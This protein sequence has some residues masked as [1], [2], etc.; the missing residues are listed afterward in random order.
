MKTRLLLSGGILVAWLGLAAA[1]SAQTISSAANQTFVVADPS[2]PISPITITDKTPPAIKANKNIIVRIPAG[3]NMTWDPT[4]TTASFTG[5]GASKVSTTVSYRNGNLDLVINVTINFA[6]GDQITVSGLNFTNFTAP[7][8]A[9]SLGLITNG[10]GGAV[11]ATDNRT[12]TIVAKVYAVAVS[13]LATTA[14]QLPSNGVNYTVAFTVTNTGNGSTSYDLLTAKQP[15]TVITT[16]SIA[17]AGITQGANPDSARLT[18]LLGGTS[19][20]ATVT[21][22]VAMA[23]SGTMDTLIFKARAVLSPATADT[24]KLTV[25]VIRP[26]MTIAKSVSPGGTQLP[27]ANLTYT[28]A[29]SNIGSSNAGRG[30]APRRRLLPSRERREHLARR[31]IGAGRLLEQRRR[32]VD[33]RANERRVRRA[34]RI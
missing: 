3:L 26:T 28:V 4:I 15:G 18:N 33:V 31:G 30:H 7:S 1:A 8:A 14:S 32:D 22:A 27:G 9:S 6:A 29:L 21:Y 34:G 25:T 19:A 17:G 11:V 2:T 5:S 24:G 20:T 23:A 16:V 12:K 13:P 10:P